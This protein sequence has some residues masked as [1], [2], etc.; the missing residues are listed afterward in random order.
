MAY[1]ALA[2]SIAKTFSIDVRE[3]SSV[4]LLDGSDLEDVD[5]CTRYRAAAGIEKSVGLVGITAHWSDGVVVE[6]LA[7]LN[8]NTTT[9]TP[10]SMKNEEVLEKLKFVVGRCDITYED[11]SP[12][13]CIEYAFADEEPVPT[14]HLSKTSNDGYE[15]FLQCKFK[16]WEKAMREP[17]CEAAFRRMLQRGLVYQMY[18]ANM[19][20]TPDHLMSKYRVT[21]EES[22][23]SVELPHP[24]AQCR[25]WDAAK[26]CFKTL[27][28]T[29]EGAPQSEAE[30]KV[31]WETFLEELRDLRGAKYIETLLNSKQQEDQM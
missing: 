17:S 14:W 23:K 25:V 28:T 7:Y 2:A 12:T 19:F 24:V 3:V 5:R 10:E 8:D 1:A 31:Y 4:R 21:D 9:L 26:R 20:P 30:A 29:L 11:L 6:Y 15:H 22:G 13:Q 27:S 16:V 18:D